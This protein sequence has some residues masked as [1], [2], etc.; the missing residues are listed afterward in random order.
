VGTGLGTPPE[1]NPTPLED[2]EE[3]SEYT[4]SILNGKPL[5]V[6]Q[7]KVDQ[8]FYNLRY[9]LSDISNNPRR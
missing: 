7:I 6:I 3:G 4:V 8:G 5:P 1:E 9:C 2:M